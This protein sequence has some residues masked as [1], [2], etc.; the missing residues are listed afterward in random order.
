MSQQSLEGS[1]SKIIYKNEA[2][3]YAVI[4]LTTESDSEVTVVGCIPFVAE[5]ENLK[6]KGAYGSHAT[7]GPQ[8]V[9]EEV[10]RTLPADLGAIVRYL[11]SG[12]IKGIGT[13]TATRIVEYFGSD[14]FFVLEATP[15]RLCEIKGITQKRAQ[16]IGMNFSVHSL[17]RSL[18]DYLATFGLEPLLALRLFERYG[19]GAA[20]IMRA[21]PYILVSDIYGIDFAK[22]DAIAEQMGHEKES[23][24][25]IEACLKHQLRYNYMEGHV[26]LPEE[27]LLFSAMQM[28]AVPEE[29]AGLALQNLVDTREIIKDTI[30]GMPV[31]YLREC[32]VDEC[33]VAERLCAMAGNQTFLC[34]NPVAAVDAL[35]T[36][37]PYTSKQ[38]EALDAIL[39]SGAA[40]I[41]GG[42]GTGKTTTVRGM[43]QLLENLQVKHLLAAPTGR[44]AKRLSE[45]CGKDAKTIHRLLECDI[46]RKTGN[47]K[48]ARNE[49]NPL[50]AEVIIVDELSMV[51][52]SLMASLLRGIRGTA[53]IVMVGD[54]DQLPSVGA[55]N[56]LSD[57]IRSEQ[58]RTIRLDEIFRQAQESAIVVNAHKVNK[59]Q[60]PNLG[61]KDN[62]F[63]FLTREAAQIADT[64]V[65]LCKRRLP[66]RQGYDPADI[67]VITP[68]RRQETGVQILNFK[69]QEALNPKTDRTKEY[70][71]GGTTFR[72]GDRVMQIKN[73]YDLLWEKDSEVGVG[74]FN[75]DTGV[76]KDIKPKDQLVIVD[77]DGRIAEYQFTM[78]GELDLAYAITVHKAQG[79]EYKAVIFACGKNNVKLCNRSLLYTAITRAREL[80]IIVG[81]E[82]T[83]AAMVDNN[84]KSRRFT[85]LKTRLTQGGSML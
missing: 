12:I 79:S 28:L 65:D 1:V 67:Q 53:R 81:L 14:T 17:L 82:E 16:E 39:T 30:A 2:N 61:L 41:T 33:Y 9:I 37:L 60:L 44:A 42:P 74:V 54:V 22:A 62:D 31:C 76:I 20:A 10:E 24:F 26:F 23:V 58:M 25:R 19:S 70:Q 63:F 72:T 57:C 78:L 36:N 51:D 73:N 29:L 21:N 8:F 84:K 47:M 50:D 32:F 7:Y 38:K 40:I 4:S 56:I 68:T 48:F 75:G 35:E 34:Q 66:E 71:W 52:L 85:G 11:A 27:G 80:F 83:V 64:I 55:G 18:I 43:I 46:D 6:V 45:L 69:L 77:Y 15:D 49:E 5:G 13:S 59:G 3:G